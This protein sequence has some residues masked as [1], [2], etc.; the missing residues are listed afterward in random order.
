[1]IWKNEIAIIVVFTATT[2]FAASAGSFKD[3]PSIVWESK[4]V[5]RAVNVVASF[6]L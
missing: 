2:E 1:M 5:K 6:I 4:G 3:G